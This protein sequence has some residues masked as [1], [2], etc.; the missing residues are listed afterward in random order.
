MAVTAAKFLPLSITAITE[1][2][3]QVDTPYNLYLYKGLPPTPIANPGLDSIRA[4]L[5]PDSTNYYFYALGNDGVHHFFRTYNE[6]VN[7]LNSLKD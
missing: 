1:A 6:H 3:K 5:Y 4:A 2:D 7:F